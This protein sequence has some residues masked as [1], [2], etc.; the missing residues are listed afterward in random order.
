MKLTRKR[1]RRGHSVQ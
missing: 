1:H